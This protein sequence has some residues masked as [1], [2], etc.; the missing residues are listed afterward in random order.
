VRPTILGEGEPEEVV[1]EGCRHPCVEAQEGVA[2]VA[3][4]C[5]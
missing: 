1:L 4:D 3:N 5:K 2:F